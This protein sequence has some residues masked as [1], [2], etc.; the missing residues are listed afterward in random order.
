M[1]KLFFTKSQ[2]MI[3][4][5]AVTKGADHFEVQKDGTL[6]K[7]TQP[8]GQKFTNVPDDSDRE[9]VRVYKDDLPDLQSAIQWVLGGQ[10]VPMATCRFELDSRGASV[11]VPLPEAKG[12]KDVVLV[13]VFGYF[14]PTLDEDE[15]R[16]IC[17]DFRLLRQ[18]FPV[19]SGIWAT[20]T[21]FAWVGP[22]YIIDI[23]E[24]SSQK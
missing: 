23:Q 6:R 13:D 5:V 7:L 1:K 17:E 2:G 24:L 4:S 14:Q 3:K 8:V 15:I 20:K 18:Y 9:K 16:Q 12:A 19:Y 21:G 22:G 11:Q 10:E